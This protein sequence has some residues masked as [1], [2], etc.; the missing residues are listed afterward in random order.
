MTGEQ[1]KAARNAIGATQHRLAALIGVQPLMVLRW[2][3]DQ[4]PVP[5]RTALL[6]HVMQGGR[7]TLE[8]L[9]T[10][11]ALYEPD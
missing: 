11:R 1:L 2:E 7:V 4:T 6:M 5:V 3:N 8:G 9:E 10:I